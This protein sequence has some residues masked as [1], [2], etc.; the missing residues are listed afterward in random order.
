MVGKN[1]KAL[2]KTENRRKEEKNKQKSK[3][4]APPSL[5]A[6]GKQ[7]KNAPAKD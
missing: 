1:K 6:E 3:Q 7:R 5:R 2:T 4:A